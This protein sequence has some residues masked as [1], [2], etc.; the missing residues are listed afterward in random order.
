[1]IA[2]GCQGPVQKTTKANSTNETG[3]K[4]VNNDWFMP[5]EG[6]PHECT[7]MSF[8]ASQ[9]I[10]GRKLIDEVRQNLATVAQTIARFEP[11]VMCVRPEELK[12]AKSYFKDLTDI[13]FVECRLNDLWIRDHGAVF[14]L[15]ES[16]ERAAIDFNFNGWG[17][18]QDYEDD[19]QVAAMMAQK[20][21]VRLIE[22][23]L[24]LEGGGVEVDGE[25]TAIITESCVINGNRNPGWSKRD[26]EKELLA[27]L[28]IEKVIWLPGVRDADITDGHTDFYARFTSP[29]VVV[30]HYDPDK[31]SPENELTL[32]QI[33]M[34]E[35]AT[36]ARGTRLRIVPLEMPSSVRPKFENADFCAGYVNFYVCNNAVIAAAFGEERTDGEA[37]E[38]LQECF[39]KREIVM[40]NIDGI[41]AGGGG[42][43]CAT[44][45]EPRA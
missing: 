2:L 13:E 36:D 21:E 19:A 3:K 12:L 27:T 15:N 29:G 45:Q 26:C 43:H 44:Q 14:V 18:K 7:W 1:M 22:T 40:L 33:K 20:S 25:G 5:E 16:G 37:K 42:I 4:T 41:A 24:C 9:K 17:E 6:D 34:L 32:R 30:A 11:V 28:G 8:G 35:T 10:W 23:D 31:T 38:K 39:P